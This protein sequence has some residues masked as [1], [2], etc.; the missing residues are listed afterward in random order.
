MPNEWIVLYIYSTVGEHSLGEHF[1]C[2]V[3]HVF[4]LFQC[5]HIYIFFIIKEIKSKVLSD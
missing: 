3:R 4:F 5:T 1:K 2:V